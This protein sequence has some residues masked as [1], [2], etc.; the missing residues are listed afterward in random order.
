LVIR[1]RV[2]ADRQRALRYQ[3]THDDLTG[4]PNRHELPQLFR[5]F[6]RTAEREPVA[7][8]MLGLNRFK[9]LNSTY[10]HAFGDTV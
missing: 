3:A 6:D 4:L 2:L 9:L 1:S 5:Q 7:L 8:V 10:G